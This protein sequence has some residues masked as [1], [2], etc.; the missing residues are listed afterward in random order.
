MPGVLMLE[1]MFQVSMWLVRLSD[2]FQYST[3]VLRQAKS[4]KYQGFVQPGDSLEVHAEIKN[5][6]GSLT[7][8][9]VSGSVAGKQ[10]TSGRLIIESF[11]LAER[12]GV[13]PAIDN[14]MSTKYRKMFRRLCNQ[15]DSN[16]LYR[17]AENQAV[18][19][20]E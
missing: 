4:L 7:S 15:L 8:L 3:V 9:K 2:Q 1:A 20:T 12:E 14:Y 5:V 6:T 19:E 13:D 10:A 17:L 11:N 16:S 18:L